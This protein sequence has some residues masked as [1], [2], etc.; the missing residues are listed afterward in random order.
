MNPCGKRDGRGGD[1]EEERGREEE[2]SPSRLKKA[3]RTI[4]SPCA[5]TL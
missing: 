5:C 2:I 1:E 4:Y 3:R